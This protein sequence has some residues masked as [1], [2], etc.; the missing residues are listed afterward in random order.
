MTIPPSGGLKNRRLTRNAGR[1]G[2]KETRILS[3]VG[4]LTEFQ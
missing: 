2:L 4:T 1:G 3:S